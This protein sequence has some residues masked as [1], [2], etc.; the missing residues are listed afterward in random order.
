MGYFLKLFPA[1]GFLLL[2]QTLY[3][4]SA[5]AAGTGEIVFTSTRDGNPEIYV[6]NPDGSGQINLTQH[7]DK[8][9]NPTWSP[10]GEQ[11][12]FVSNRDGFYDLYLMNP[13]GE[14]V[15]RV[16]RENARREQPTW[17]PDGKRI[18]YAVPEEKSIKIAAITGG[19]EKHLTRI[20]GH[21]GHPAWSPDGTEIAYGWLSSGSIRT[22]NLNTDAVTSLLP[23]RGFFMWHP[24][25]SPT[26][27]RIAFA[28][29]KR[30]KNHVG[31]LIVTD[32]TTL[33]IFDRDGMW[34]KH[35]VKEPIISHPTWSPN[36]S[37]ILYERRIGHHKQLFKVDLKHRKPQQLTHSGENYFADWIDNPRLPVEP[38]PLTL[39]TVWG[40]LKRK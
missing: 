11:I 29:V 5:K 23:R 17:S 7:A 33:Y 8:D 15:Q 19:P 39:T 16:F 38:T 20:D 22:I 37:E 25:W 13:D 12:L 21:Y 3:S 30:P 28:G 27:N 2:C 4:I 1:I 32:K 36:G 40:E 31:A 9:F 35:I 18:A 10:D 14:N 34:V 26:E 6:M 24:A